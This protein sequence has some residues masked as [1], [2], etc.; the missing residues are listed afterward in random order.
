MIS[1]MPRT[2]QSMIRRTMPRM[3]RKAPMVTAISLPVTSDGGNLDETCEKRLAPQ[4]NPFAYK[5]VA[6]RA[7]ARRCV[8]GSGPDSE[9]G[10][11]K[12]YP[13]SFPGT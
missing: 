1:T 8:A 6:S 5:L 13:T 2:V 7:V 4:S 9:G 10:A 11:S 3:M 12:A